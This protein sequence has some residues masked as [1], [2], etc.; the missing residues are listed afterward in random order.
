MLTRSPCKMSESMYTGPGEV[1]L[2]P[3]IWGDIVPILLDG[4]TNW[5]MGREAFLACTMGVTRT[6]KG[7]GLGKAMCACIFFVSLYFTFT[8]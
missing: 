4:R 6:I 3:E 5:K 8:V 2:A 1:L 7:Q